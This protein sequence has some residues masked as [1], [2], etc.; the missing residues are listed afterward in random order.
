M[1]TIDDYLADLDPD[2]RE[3]VERVYDI[4]REVVPEAEQG[5]GYGMPALVHH[6]KSLIS[7]M[8]AKNHIGVYPFSPAAIEAA[9]DMLVG[10]DRDKGTVRFQPETPLRE[11]AIRRMVAFRRDQIDG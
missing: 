5:K 7:V 9:A 3:A 6:G 8:R 10:V 1:G 11:D 4:A 2:D